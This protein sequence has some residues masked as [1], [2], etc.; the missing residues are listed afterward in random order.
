M[1]PGPARSPRSLSRSSQ[2]ASPSPLALIQHPQA[3]SGSGERAPH[4]LQGLLFYPFSTTSQG[5]GQCTRHQRRSPRSLSRSSQ[6]ASP[7]PHPDGSGTL[8]NSRLF[9]PFD[10]ST[11]C[12]KRSWSWSWSCSWSRE[13]DGKSASETNFLDTFLLV[14]RARATGVLA[15]P[16]LPVESRD[17]LVFQPACERAS[18]RRRETLGARRCESRKWAC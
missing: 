5:R 8:R 10:L 2:S 7:S 12:K 14:P 3:A 11:F 9:S 16:P 13:L 1:H 17:R 18:S 15:V 6:C 4:P